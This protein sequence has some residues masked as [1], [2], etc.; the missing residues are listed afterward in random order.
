MRIA[1]SSGHGAHLPGAVGVIREHDEARR[2]TNRV[3]ELLTGMGH[4]AHVFHDEDSCDQNTNV[5]TIVGWHNGLRR[6]R[7]VSIHFN[8]VEGRT[9]NPIGTEV[10]VH[11]GADAPTRRWASTVAS[12]MATAGGFSLR[13]PGEFPG[14]LDLNVGFTRDIQGFIDGCGKGSIL[15]EVCFVNSEADSR[16]YNDNFEK[17]CVAIAEALEV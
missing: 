6:D 16:L 12:A 15:L 3:A 2:V 1:I 14:V 10:V 8:A 4:T 9:A 5:R 17:I 11:G 7:D 13:R